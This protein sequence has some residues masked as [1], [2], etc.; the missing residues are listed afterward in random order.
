MTNQ[1]DHPR[2]TVIVG[3]LD[4]EPDHDRAVAAAAVLAVVGDVPIVLVTVSSPGLPDVTDRIDLR[5]IAEEHRLDQWSSVVLH[6]ND[7]ARA[8][9]AY[10]RGLDAPL[11]VIATGVRGMISGLNSADITADLLGEISSPALVLGPHVPETWQP[12]QSQLICCVPRGQTSAAVTLW[13][14]R[15]LATFGGTNPRFVSVVPSDAPANDATPSDQVADPGGRHTDW[16]LVHDDDVV[17]G[18]LVFAADL[19]DGV[20]VVSSERWSDDTRLHRHS[21]ARHL[22]HNAA[23]PVLILPRAAVS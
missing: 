7:P 18:L 16:T 22:A 9:S 21:I 4:L 10:V 2:F 19:A 14:A 1:A 8:L 5:R 12:R 6:D 20:L 15:W 23:V 11:V 17:N 3:P 13:T